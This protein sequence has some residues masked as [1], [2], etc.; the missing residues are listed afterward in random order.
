M[1]K[2]Y[3]NL[4]QLGTRCPSG[5]GP[6]KNF[7]AVFSTYLVLILNTYQIIPFIIEMLTCAYLHVVSLI[8]L[9]VHS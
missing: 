7:T 5:I 4:N 8:H 2:Y 3:F 9:F 6:F 1:C